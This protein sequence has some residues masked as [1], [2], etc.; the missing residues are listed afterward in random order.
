M[1]GQRGG[2]DKRREHS[3]RKEATDSTWLASFSRKLKIN[4]PT[5]CQENKSSKVCVSVTF[6]TAAL[7]TGW[8]DRQRRATAT[9]RSEALL[10]CKTHSIM[11]KIPL[12]SPPCT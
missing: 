11:T 12:S 5:T 7:G 4:C 1:T 2:R 9:P 6:P 10:D 8:K 3:G